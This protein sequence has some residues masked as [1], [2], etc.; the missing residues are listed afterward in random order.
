MERSVSQPKGA[1]NQNESAGNISTNAGVVL[2]GS[3]DR[4]YETQVSEVKPL[5][6]PE[7]AK[8]PT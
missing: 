6:K 7:G 1:K 5:E 2:T 8:T 3:D 4:P